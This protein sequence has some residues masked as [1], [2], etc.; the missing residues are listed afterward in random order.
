MPGGGG[1][2]DPNDKPGL[3]LFKSKEALDTRVQD[4]KARGFT[5]FEF[6]LAKYKENG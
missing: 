1:T 2:G 6:V 3:E 5:Y 4:L